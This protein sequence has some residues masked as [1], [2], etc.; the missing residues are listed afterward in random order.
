LRWYFFTINGP[1]EPKRFEEKDVALRQR[2]FVATLWNSSV[3][4]NTYVSKIPNPKSQIPKSKNILDQWILAK[5]NILVGQVTD[6]LEK[7]DLVGTARAIDEFTINDFS[8]WFVR[9]SRRRFQHPE[10]VQEKNEAAAVMAQVLLTLAELTA[11][12]APFISEAV[13]QGLRRK[14]S[15]LREESVHLRVWPKSEKKKKDAKV[16]QDMEWARGI[17]AETLKLRAEAGIKVRQPLAKLQISS[18][19]LQ[20]QSAMLDLIQDEVNVKEIVFGNEIKLD[21]ILTLELREEG[22]TRE[23]VRNIQE[24][25]RE[26]HLAPKQRV[27]ILIT[28]ADAILAIEVKYGQMIQKETK[29]HIVVRGVGRKPSRAE[30]VLPFTDGELRIE[31]L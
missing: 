15:G 16:I 22:M 28:R 10:S 30:R 27:D 3:F 12:F 17:V 8:Q 1:G 14:M 13:Y 19:K 31:I 23:I 24:M 9:R 18:D 26:L 11:P 7:Y 29:S 6:G 21:T 4:F 20:K 25:R 2:G 5:L